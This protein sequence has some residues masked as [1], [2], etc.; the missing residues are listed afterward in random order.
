MNYAAISI[1]WAFLAFN[2]TTGP[3][4]QSCQIKSKLEISNIF[5]KH[6]VMSRI[7]DPIQQC[8]C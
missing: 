5:I 1:L 6:S 7:T 8:H 4:P 2:L 3:T